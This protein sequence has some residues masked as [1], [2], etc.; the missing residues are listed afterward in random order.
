MTYDLQTQYSSPNFSDGPANGRHIESITIHHWG[1]N[2]QQFSVVR[3]YLCNG[4]RPN[5]TS[6]HYVAQGGLVACIVDPSDIAWHAGSWEGNV[7]SIGI[8]CRP[9]HS[10]QDYETIAELVRNL[11]AQYGNLPLHP[12]NHWTQTACPGDYDLN[13]I[14]KLAGQV[15]VSPASTKKEEE[16]SKIV[17]F[18][19][20]K[21]SNRLK[22]NVYRTLKIS[23]KDNNA[24]SI[25]KENESA[26]FD[27][28]VSL[29]N[30]PKGSHA[31]LQVVRVDTKNSKAVPE[32]LTWTTI[33]SVGTVNPSAQIS[34]HTSTDSHHRVRARVVVWKDGVTINNVKA[35]KRV[36]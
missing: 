9:E 33:N 13:R 6:A 10:D 16:V 36:F 2:G 17:T 4:D 32:V 22:P 31:Q 27:L 24:A 15:S 3:D 19:R 18:Y 11:R 21:D 30:L 12:H 28:A 1:N 34:C 35:E 23:D 7:T 5:P 25:L 29:K 20:G 14:N 26:D 8:E